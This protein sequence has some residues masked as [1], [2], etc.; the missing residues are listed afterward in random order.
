MPCYAEHGK[1]VMPLGEKEEKLKFNKILKAKCE[2]RLSN[3]DSKGG[4]KRTHTHANSFLTGSPK[5]RARESHPGGHMH[6]IKDRQLWGE[7]M[8]KHTSFEEPFLHSPGRKLFKATR[9]DLKYT[10]LMFSH[11][12]CSV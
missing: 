10:A 8:W 12:T 4:M 5:Y 11:C 3:Y 9:E 1:K 7:Q 2:A 6:A